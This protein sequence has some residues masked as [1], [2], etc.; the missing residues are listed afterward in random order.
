VIAV[1][2]AVDKR[3]VS[4]VTPFLYMYFVSAAGSLGMFPFVWRAFK[5]ADLAREW[6]SHRVSIVAGGLLQYAA[7]GLVLSAFE[8]ARVSYVGPFREIGI[9]VGV[10]LGAIVLRERFG[11]GRVLGA[12]IV[13]LG[14]ALVALA[15]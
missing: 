8:I 15:P 1:Y 5:R 14:A 3:G 12:V 9:V 7:Y 10:L 13:A 11:R 4:H 2:S 6:R